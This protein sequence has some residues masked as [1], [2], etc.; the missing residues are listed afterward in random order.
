M[1]WVPITEFNIKMLFIY[2]KIISKK[3]EKKHTSII[4]SNLRHII[5]IYFK[6]SDV[7]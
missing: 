5:I 4:V 6:I 7:K 1:H 2:D 3:P